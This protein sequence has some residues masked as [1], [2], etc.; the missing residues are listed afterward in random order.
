M[1][2]RFERNQTPG[3]GFFFFF[4]GGGQG[5]VFN[6]S[7]EIGDGKW[8]METALDLMYLLAKS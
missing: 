1:R 4:G 8:V 3:S 6:T 7:Y 5:G 2:S